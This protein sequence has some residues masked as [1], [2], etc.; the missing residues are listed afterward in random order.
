M[1]QCVQMIP[2]IFVTW[3]AKWVELAYQDILGSIINHRLYFPTT[4]KIALFI[5]LIVVS[6][7]AHDFHILYA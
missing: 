5:S 4:V 1:R 3:F 6:N 7:M 2:P